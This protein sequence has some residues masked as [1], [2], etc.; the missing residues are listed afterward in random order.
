L[1]TIERDGKL[2]VERVRSVTRKV[3]EDGSAI[4]CVQ[5]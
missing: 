2:S 5:L 3:Y 1:A 4:T